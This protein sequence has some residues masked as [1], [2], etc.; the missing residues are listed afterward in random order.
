MNYQILIGKE[1]NEL[2]TNTFTNVE[3]G[4]EVNR[5]IVTQ[6]DTGIDFVL[7]RSCFWCASYFNFG[8]MTIVSCPMC[9]NNHIDQL[10]VSID[11]V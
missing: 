1:Q 8:E 2:R 10:P 9:Y 6:N 3:N 4:S 7:C 11:Q 5:H